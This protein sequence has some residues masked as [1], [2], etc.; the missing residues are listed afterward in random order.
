MTSEPQTLGA[1]Q[2]VFILIF[3]GENYP[4]YVYILFT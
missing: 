3:R 2:N 1:L 4:Y